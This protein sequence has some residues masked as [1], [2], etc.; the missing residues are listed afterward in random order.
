MLMIGCVKRK[1]ILHNLGEVFQPL[2]KSPL[3]DAPLPTGARNE[4]W[5][6][7]ICHDDDHFVLVLCGWR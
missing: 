2:S 3:H 1:W 5:I 7:E 6:S 4:F